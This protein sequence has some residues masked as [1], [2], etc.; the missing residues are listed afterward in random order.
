MPMS[1]YIVLNC[2]LYLSIFWRSCNVSKVLCFV[3]VDDITCT[4]ECFRACRI[5]V[6]HAHGKPPSSKKFG[7]KVI[8]WWSYLTNGIQVNDLDL[9]SQ[10]SYFGLCC[11]QIHPCLTITF[12]SRICPDTEGSSKEQ[13]KERKAT[14]IERPPV[15]AP[16][17]SAYFHPDKTEAVNNMQYRYK[18]LWVVPFLCFLDFSVGVG[19][20]VIGLSQISSFLFLF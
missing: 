17:S 2:N 1:I 8:M 12:W 18:L 20:F 6:F 14:P 9:C 13:G 19:A 7:S 4:A 11:L 3:T 16:L 10:K 5:N 15:P